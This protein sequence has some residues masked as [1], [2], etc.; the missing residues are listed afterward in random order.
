LK[1]SP[2][3]GEPNA[4]LYTSPGIDVGITGSKIAVFDVA[5]PSPIRIEKRGRIFLSLMKVP[6]LAE[7]V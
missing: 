1:N 4:S 2:G 5:A 3:V 6:L 7:A